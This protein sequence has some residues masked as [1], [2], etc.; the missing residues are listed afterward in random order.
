MMD[1]SVV[2]DPYECLSVQFLYLSPMRRQPSTGFAN[3]SA[4]EPCCRVDS[5]I[6][7]CIGPRFCVESLRS[8]RRFFSKLV[9]PR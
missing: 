5:Q 6:S 1:F 8:F 9:I 3:K 7:R 4:S 2:F